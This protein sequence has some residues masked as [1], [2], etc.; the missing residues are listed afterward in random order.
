MSDLATPL[1][2]SALQVT[3]LAV[4]GLA[5]AAVL[6]RRSAGAAAFLTAMTLASCCPLTVLAFAPLPDWWTWSAHELPTTATP[7][8]PI[9]T[10]PPLAEESGVAAGPVAE[11]RPVRSPGIDL[12]WLRRYGKAVAASLEPQR[13]RRWPVVLAAAVL[14]GA[15]WC[16]GR[17]AFGLWAVGRMVRR[18]RLIDDPGLI[19]LTVRLCA[20][21]GVTR[22]VELRECD[23]LSSAATVGWRRPIILLPPDWAA[24]GETERRA[25]LA[26]ELAHVRRRDFLTALLARASLALHFYH[27]LVHWLVRRLHLQQE[28]AADAL[29][30]RFAGGTGP[31]LRVLAR[32]ALYQDGRAAA[33]SAQA[34][35]SS[36]GTLLRRIS[37]LQ[38]RDGVPQVAPRRG[39]RAAGWALLALAALVASALRSPA[40]KHDQPAPKS[41]VTSPGDT[42]VA[43][44]P[45]PPFDL[46]YLAPDAMGAIAFRPA[47]LFNRP[48]MK[49]YRDQVNEGI[50]NVL[51]AVVKGAGQIDLNIEDIEQV[52]LSSHVAKIKDAKPGGPQNS[53]NAHMAVIHTVRAYDWK[54]TL[55]ALAPDL[56]EIEVEGKTCFVVPKV[57]LPMQAT[58]E[59]CVC[60]P[61]ERTVIV[62]SEDAI[63]KMLRANKQ[64]RPPPTWAADW[65]QVECSLAAQAVADIRPLMKERKP[66]EDDSDPAL[67]VLRSSKS[68]VMGLDLNDGVA[69]QLLVRAD[70]EQEAEKLLETTR[71]LMKDA[72]AKFTEDRKKA[73]KPQTREQESAW[74]V[75]EELFTKY[76]LSRDGTRVHLRACSKAKNVVEVL[77]AVFAGGLEM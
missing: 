29:S 38:A 7:A 22:P 6:A 49:R 40:Q 30:L 59:I 45:V 23:E 74:R 64:Q 57:S 51:A 16:L 31:Y 19:G 35:L 73:A 34:F 67:V 48:D 53:L 76:E 10:S 12:G 14:A 32:M 60:V 54:K 69:G 55:S 28:L 21:L 4:A 11:T 39:V 77:T 43:A 17:L 1:F 46:S 20:D 25:V 5:L 52:V 41:E 13:E 62:D 61:D 18:S 3:C 72:Y 65:K 33:G 44:A 50:H 8:Q 15:A 63:R 47:A 68:L 58:A 66:S 2:W 36:P 75:I 9:A 70:N 71:G 27:P 24:W 37:M 26:H 42:P 56:K